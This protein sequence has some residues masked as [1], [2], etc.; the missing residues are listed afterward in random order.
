VAALADLLPA[1]ERPQRRL[2]RVRLPFLRPAAPRG[3]EA[4]PERY[5]LQLILMAADAL[6]GAA[7]AAQGAAAAML[8][9]RTRSRIPARLLGRTDE[10]DVWFKQHADEIADAAKSLASGR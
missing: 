10:L 6:P 8:A 3:L 9:E 1:G 5:R 7:P 2:S 4:V